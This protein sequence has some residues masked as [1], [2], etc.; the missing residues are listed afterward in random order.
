[1]PAALSVPEVCTVPSTA[2]GE[3]EIT[4]TDECLARP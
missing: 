1:M 2:R 4:L 3:G